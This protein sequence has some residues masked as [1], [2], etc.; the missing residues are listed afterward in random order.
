ML[1]QERL[2]EILDYDKYSGIFTWKEK[3]NRNTIIGAIAGNLD[4]TGY[5][6]ICIS[7][8]KYRANRLAWFYEYGKWPTGL[9]DHIDRIKNN[10]KINNLRDVTFS[11]NNQNRTKPHPKNTTGLLGVSRSN[12]R[13]KSII[14]VNK[15]IISLGTFATAEE[16]HQAYMTAK[17]KYHIEVTL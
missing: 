16:A 8:K 17:V 6:R 11:Q 14:R 13:F 7:G 9:I 4:P 3:I 12:H 2:K 1:T 10:D 15:S 5:I